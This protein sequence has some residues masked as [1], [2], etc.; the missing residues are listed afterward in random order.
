MDSL[1]SQDN[2]ELTKRLSKCEESIKKVLLQVKK[3]PSV[4]LNQIEKKVDASVT[5]SVENLR[6]V[7][8]KY[9]KTQRVM[10]KEIYELS[11]KFNQPTAPCSERAISSFKSPKGI[12]KKPKKTIK[13]N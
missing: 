8:E 3:K 9:T 13:L 4:N 10:Q 11:A 1:E 2:S 5:K 6:K 7:M 12:L